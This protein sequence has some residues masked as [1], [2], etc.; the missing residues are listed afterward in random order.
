MRWCGVSR[1]EGGR[2]SRCVDAP[3][4][5]HGA[6]GV[7]ADAR[8]HELVHQRNVLWL[9]VFGPSCEILLHENNV[10]HAPRQLGQMGLEGGLAQV[11][12][13]GVDNDVGI[14]LEGPVQLA[15]LLQAEVERARLVGQEALAD[16]GGDGG[17]VVNARV[18]EV[19]KFGV[20]GKK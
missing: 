5:Q 19:G 20:H 9:L 17:D 16:A 4:D 7:L 11:L 12:L 8:A 6:E 13:A 14:V 10:V 18:L 1:L 2:G 3:N 15:Q